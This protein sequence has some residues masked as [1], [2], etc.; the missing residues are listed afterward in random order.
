MGTEDIII[1]FTFRNSE[2]YAILLTSLQ[3]MRLS[4]NNI[5]AMLDRLNII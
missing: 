5:I 4:T 1:L 2:V 3:R